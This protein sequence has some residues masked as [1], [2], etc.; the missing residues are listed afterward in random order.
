M[1]DFWRVPFLRDE[2]KN[3][4]VLMSAKEREN[5]LRLAQD[6]KKRKEEEL[7]SICL[8]YTSPSPRD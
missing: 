6:R 4:G 8:L 7:L 3:V 2:L 1:G 5:Q